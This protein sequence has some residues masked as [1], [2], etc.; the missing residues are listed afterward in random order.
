MGLS[1]K[2]PHCTHVLFLRRHVAVIHPSLALAGYARLSLK[3]FARLRVIVEPGAG[4]GPTPQMWDAVA[5]SLTEWLELGVK[6]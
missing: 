1:A 5:A 2:D 3:G 6:L 4:H